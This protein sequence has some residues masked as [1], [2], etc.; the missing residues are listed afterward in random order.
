MGKVNKVVIVGGVAGGASAAARLRRLG[1]D[2]EIL[3]LDRGPYVSFA[4]CGLP[5]Y[6]GDVIQDERKLL[7][8]SE[9]LFRDRFN[10]AVRTRHE[11]I[12][13]D[14]AEQTIE[15]RNLVSGE[16][17]QESYDALVLSPGAKALRPPFPGVDLPGVFVL[18]TI[19]DSRQIRGWLEEKEAK[20]AVVVGGG[21][22]GLEMAENLVHRG[23]EVTVIELSPQV[24]PPLD[25]EMADPVAEHLRAKGVRLCLGDGVAAFEEEATGLRVKTQS[26]ESFPAD[27][28]ILAIGVRPETQL[29]QAAGLEL[30][31][32]G[33][34]KVDAQM[35]TS[36]PQ[37]WAVGDAV[38]VEDLITKTP[39]LIPLAGPANRQGR[40]AADSI[41]GREVAFRGVQGTAVCGLFGLVVAATGATERC[42]SRAK[43]EHAQAVYLHPG[44][45][46]GY[47]PG[48]KAIHIKVVY[49]GR[50][51]RLLGAQAVGEEGVAR[52]IDVISL[53]IQM[54]G[55]VFDLEQAE[56]CY[57]PQFGAA[58]DPVNLA[59]MIAANVIRGDHPA[60]RWEDLA[61][62]KVSLVD[63]R[64]PAEFER[65]HVEGALSLPLE[66]LR[67]RSG[68]LP[69]DRPIW[70]YCRVGQRGYY[71]TRLLAQR[72]F[73]VKN[74]LGGILTYETVQRSQTTSA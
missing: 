57:A 7:V 26:G 71:A 8:A 43:F 10:I 21:F 74:L 31:Q 55:T 33:G 36:D 62:A 37:V 28:V 25:V 35:R 18:R 70:V 56:L 29:A 40:L 14:R 42:L 30:G 45:H 20:R 60:A 15:V 54:G 58:K 66:E 13:I 47:Y 16:T 51:G 41:L 63:V 61:E 44:H 11:V 64:S 19:P 32:L 27:I 46:V 2:C 52:R 12:S 53:A 50:D 69:Q 24:M 23:L 34:I 6:V 3:V 39:A 72:G 65:G 9:A 68:E 17:Y 49:D 5:Y 4:N 67:A 73:D 1:E 48:A 22:V 59:G 38:E